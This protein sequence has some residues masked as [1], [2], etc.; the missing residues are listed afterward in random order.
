MKEKKD[1]LYTRL[2]RKCVAVEDVF[3]SRRNI[4]AVRGNAPV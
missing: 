2:I 3:C 4:T 1:K